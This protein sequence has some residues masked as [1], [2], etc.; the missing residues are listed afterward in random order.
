VECEAPNL[1]RIYL[2]S[3]GA[4]TAYTS[5]IFYRNGAVIADD[6]VFDAWGQ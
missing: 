2:E 4:G 1:G 3:S 5:G 6:L